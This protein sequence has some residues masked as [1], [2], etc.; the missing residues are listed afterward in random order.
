MRLNSKLAISVGFVLAI[1][2]VALTAEVSYRNAQ[3]LVTASDWVARSNEVRAELEGAL[4]D[5]TQTEAAQRGFTI[6]G[7]HTYLN[8]YETAVSNSEGHLR[9]LQQLT[10]NNPAQQRKLSLVEQAV[11]SKLEWQSGVIET[12]QH[13]GA[14]AAE[15]MVAGGRGHHAML[16]I[17]RLV[18]EMENEEGQLLEARTAQARTTAATTLNAAMLFSMTV[19]ILLGLACLLILQHLGDRERAQTALEETQQKLRLALENEAELARLDPLTRLANRRAFFELLEAERSRTIRYGRPLTLVYLDLDAFKQVN[20]SMG[21]AVGDELLKTVANTLRTSLRASDTVARVGGD[22]FSLL[23]PESGLGTAEVVL[24]K[25]QS[26]LLTAMHEQHW[27][28]TFSMGAVTFLRLPESCD[29]MLHAADQLMY[30]VKTHG[31]NGIAVET[32]RP[33]ANPLAI[34]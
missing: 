19:A 14:A 9:H 10:A 11:Y 28:V 2:A 15:A 16:E 34:Q 22:E 24:R 6:T 29:E 31:K 32:Y 20:D 7:D 18:T 13:K 5:I 30:E 3:G 12:R 17:Q 27:P 23:L 4:G 33:A 8:Q 25:L 1:L 21:H 26:R